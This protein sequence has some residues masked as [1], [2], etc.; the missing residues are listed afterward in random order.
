MKRQHCQAGGFGPLPTDSTT[1]LLDTQAVSRVRDLPFLGEVRCLQR[2]PK[3]RQHPAQ[4]LS[5]HPAAGWQKIQE[6]PL[7]SCQT[8]EQLLLSGCE[9]PQFIL[10]RSV[11]KRESK[12]AS[13]YNP[14]AVR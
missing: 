10:H 5:V 6:R 13:F 14:G 12:S 7:P 8:M 1:G 2:A 9:T 4:P 11:R 3:E